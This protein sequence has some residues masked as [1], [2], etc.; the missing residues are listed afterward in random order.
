MRLEAQTH[1]RSMK[2]HMPFDALPYAKDVRYIHVARDG[3]DA[4]MSYH[5]QITR[6]KPEMLEA[7]NKLGMEDETIGKPYPTFP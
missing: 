2:S 5:N 4:C 3:R 7:L 6:F 1:R